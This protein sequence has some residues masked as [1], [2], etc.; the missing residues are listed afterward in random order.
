MVAMLLTLLAAV[1]QVVPATPR[2]VS[3]VQLVVERTELA[4]PV[5]GGSTLVITIFN[6]GPKPIH[7]WA[8]R[9]M[10]TFADGQTRTS[11]RWSDACESPF[12]ED[13]SSGP[14][15]PGMRRILRSGAGFRTGPEG[16]VAVGAGVNAVIFEDDTAAGEEKNI[17]L[18][19]AQRAENQRTWPV[20]EQIVREALTEG[21]EP[22]AVL[23][24]META[25]K[26]ARAAS[27]VAVQQTSAFLWTLGTLSS[28]IRITRNPAG[29]LE[30]VVTGVRERRHAADAH[31]RR[32]F[33]VE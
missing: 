15:L 20:V 7:A 1:Q 3:P 23:E 24:R 8:L 30:T 19:F 12:R 10:V 32:K 17:E 25:L 9:T 26:A 31:Y 22:D 18:L 33:S 5:A 27:G 16:P 6:P 11:E 29:L 4:D 2:P 13:G 21:G 28:N 14:L